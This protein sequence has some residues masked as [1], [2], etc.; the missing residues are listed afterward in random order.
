MNGE[1]RCCGVLWG[2]GIAHAGGRGCAPPSR[3]CSQPVPVAY[4]PQWGGGRRVRQQRK[5]TRLPAAKRNSPPS[6]CFLRASCAHPL[7]PAALGFLRFAA[8]TAQEPS[9]QLTAFHDL[10]SQ[11]QERLTRGGSPQNGAGCA[12][13]QCKHNF[14]LQCVTYS[15]CL[16]HRVTKSRSML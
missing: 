2:A 8:L 5:G 13:E 15:P 4:S 12:P 14:V 9:S 10:R 1:L 3:A 16:L 11:E 6:S 7:A